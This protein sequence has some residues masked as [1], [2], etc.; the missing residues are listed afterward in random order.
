MPTKDLKGV[1]SELQTWRNQFLGI[2]L[3]IPDLTEF[4]AA[5]D[6]REATISALDAQ[7]ASLENQIV[8]LQKSTITATARTSES[9]MRYAEVLQDTNQK[10]SALSSALAQAQ[11][12]YDAKVK[13]LDLDFKLK[14][15]AN[16]REVAQLDAAVAERRA[17]FDTVTEAFN[18]FRTEHKLG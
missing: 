7:K 6:N 5:I 17:A 12:D 15:E 1:L 11:K 16:A 8:E 18:K 9:E 2:G 4:I 3:L 13:E 10:M 14:E